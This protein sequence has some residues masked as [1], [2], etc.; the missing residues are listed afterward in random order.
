MVEDIMHLGLV[1]EAELELDK[2]ALEIAALDHAKADLSGYLE[3]LEQITERLR[4]CSASPA[5]SPAPR[6]RPASASA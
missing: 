3:L 6:Q 4:A 5:P 2:A 1:D